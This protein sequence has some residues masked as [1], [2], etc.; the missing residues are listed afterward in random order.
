MKN[1]RAAW[2]LAAMTVANS[3]IL[4]DQTAVP[5]ALPEIIKD[6]DAGQ[7]EAQWVLTASVL[8]LAIFMVLGGRLGDILGHRR[9]F[10]TGSVLF[11][12]ASGIAGAAPDIE[13]LIIARALQG[14]GA[15]LMMPT[16][17][18]IVSEAYAE[19]RRG[20]ALG[21]MAGVTAIFAAFGPLLGGALTQLNFRLV[22]Y[23]NV[24]LAAATVILTLIFVNASRTRSDSRPQLDIPGLI[25]FA[26]VA[27]GL[28]IGLTQGRQWGWNSF[29]TLALLVS[30]IAAL[31]LFI[32]VELRRE[33]PM[34]DLRLLQ[35]PNFA[36]S[37]LSQF[38]GGIVEFGLGALLPLILILWLG[39]SPATAGLALLPATVPMILVAPL[40]GHLF[41]RYGGK[42]VLATSF[43]VLSG[44]IIWI[45]VFLGSENYWLILPGL[46]LQGSAL[47]ALLT[48][49]DPLGIN[50]VREAERGEASGMIG[51]SEQLGGAFGI[52]ILMTITVTLYLES[53]F[54]RLARDG[55]STTPEQIEQL[56][57]TLV[58]A[59]ATGLNP[60][61]LPTI[62][63]V[64]IEPAGLSFV[65]GA[66][67]ALLAAVVVCVACGLLSLVLVRNPQEP[68][69]M[70]SH[71]S[72]ATS[73]R[74]SRWVHASHS[75]TQR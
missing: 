75:R 42:Y 18:A 28:I 4:V 20:R 21:T 56:K 44:S 74:R 67:I 13:I 16:S 27:A 26:V 64:I 60:D 70:H 23:V 32:A 59:E 61:E 40:A 72:M 71:R 65:F 73:T 34:I 33:D 53:L 10:L 36:M 41:D 2:V 6:L 57:D 50:A 31:A 17:I 47:C 19:S 62:V 22:F 46:V 69:S 58:S 52:A 54:D 38:A 35:R 11:I 37:N 39:M 51:T 15:A 48:V 5:L 24:P 66:R 45:I 7:T 3:M 49:N 29:A 63:A 14:L 43:L 1:G 25:L 9:V 8:P 30:A 55:V 68:D 12:S